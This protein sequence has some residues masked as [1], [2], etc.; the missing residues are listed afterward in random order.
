MKTSG[1]PVEKY[2]VIGVMLSI[3]FAAWGS[4]YILTKY[5][6][7]A[8]IWISYR[9]SRHVYLNFGYCWA[10]IHKATV[11]QALL[12]VLLLQGFVVLAPEILLSI[13]S[14]NI[15]SVLRMVMMN[16]ILVY[17]FLQTIKTKNRIGE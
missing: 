8:D 16:S 7:D 3:V 12:G 14:R 11:G 4:D 10:S 17:G 6:Y 5:W 13:F 2:K 1:L 15:Y 9:C